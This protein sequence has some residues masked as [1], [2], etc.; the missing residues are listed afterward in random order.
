MTTDDLGD[1]MKDYE[2]AEAGR[3]CMPRLP[4]LARID[5]RGF[6]KFTGGLERPYDRRLSDLMVDTVKF[7]V[8]ETNAVC[9]YTQ[10]DEISL[11]WYAAQHRPA[12]SCSTVASARWCR[13]SPA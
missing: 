10:S 9:G 12:R 3:R 7:L 13:S 1:R 6:S 2:M 8:R 11:A 5:G 4:I